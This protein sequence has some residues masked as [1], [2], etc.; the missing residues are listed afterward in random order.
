M[1]AA[2]AGTPGA[3]SSIASVGPNSRLGVAAGAGLGNSSTALFMP[4]STYK[5]TPCGGM[6]ADMV[7]V[8]L[9]D[10]STKATVNVAGV[11]FTAAPLPLTLVAE[12][13]VASDGS[14]S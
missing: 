5:L 10:G 2:Y 9:G 6:L 3:Q 13:V 7:G 1:P 14:P 12:T 4:L 11:A 8:G